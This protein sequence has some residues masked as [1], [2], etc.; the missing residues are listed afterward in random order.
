LYLKVI[1]LQRKIFGPK[2]LSVAITAACMGDVYEKIGEYTTAMEYFEESLRIKT[3]ANGRHSL[4]VARLL[5]K[6]GKMAFL[7][8]DYHTAESFISRTVLI[9]RLNKVEKDHEWI[10]DANR[11][12]AD[13]DAAI[14]LGKARA[15]C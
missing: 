10:V 3:A 9:Y 5:H 15:E 8:G 6:L 2:H 13:I 4:D 7:S 14:A 12:S 1:G 11:D